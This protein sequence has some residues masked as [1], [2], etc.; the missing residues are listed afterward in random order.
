MQNEKAQWVPQ[1]MVKRKVIEIQ[2]TVISWAIQ[3][4]GSIQK[5][6]SSIDCKTKNGDFKS[7]VPK[8]TKP[9]EKSTTIVQKIDSYLSQ[10][11]FE[12]ELKLGGAHWILS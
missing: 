5:R 1:V 10:F 6:S 9:T 2:Y 3:W 7:Y 11:D 4:G 12:Y 8:K